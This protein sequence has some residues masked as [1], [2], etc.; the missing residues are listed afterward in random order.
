MPLSNLWRLPRPLILASKSQARRALLASAGIPFE[1]IDAQIDERVVEQPLRS[2]GC[3]G[4][5]I[6]AALAREKALG[7]SAGLG[8]RLVLGA[9]QTLSID[10]EILTKPADRDEARGQIARMAGKTHSLHAAFCLSRD[11]TIVAEACAEARLTCRMFTD[12]FLECYLELAGDSVLQSVGGYAVE[13]LGIHLF[14][15]IEGEH[16]TILGLSLLN[17]LRN[18]R[19]I[20]A[21]ER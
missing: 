1:A 21:L 13:G 19:D 16:S 9:D 14:E 4:A 20:G 7:V 3:G 6:A 17:L 11:E 12:E 15:R 2:Q 5:A 8:D 10:G 18:L